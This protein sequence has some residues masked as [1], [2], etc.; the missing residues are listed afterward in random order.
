[1][2]FD[3]TI[4]M[5]LAATPVAQPERQAKPVVAHAPNT[6]CVTSPRD[7]WI[8]WLE[9]Q[10]RLKDQG[11]RLVQLRIGEDRCFAITALDTRGEYLTLLMHPVSGKI[12]SGAKG[13]VSP[14]ATVPWRFGRRYEEE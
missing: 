5:I 12:V 6:L 9:V 4:A 1:M 13:I 3:T 10:D 11:M 2:L 7:G 8:S 14:R